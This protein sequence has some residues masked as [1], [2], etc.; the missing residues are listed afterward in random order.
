MKLVGERAAPEA[1]RKAEREK[2]LYV[3]ALWSPA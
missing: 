1:K 3:S 2:D